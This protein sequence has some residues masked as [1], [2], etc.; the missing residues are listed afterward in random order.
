MDNFRQAGSSLPQNRSM[1]APRSPSPNA[2][3]ND[4]LIAERVTTLLNHY[5]TAADDPAV[6]KLQIHD[7]L[8]DLS[9]FPAAW[10]A[11]ACQE[12]RRSQSRRPL[13]SNIRELCILHREDERRRALPPQQRDFEREAEVSTALAQ[14]AD[15]AARWRK[16]CAQEAGLPT[17][18][19]VMD[20]G[21][22]VAGRAW[23]F[24]NWDGKL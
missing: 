18:R 3:L 8:D 17:F 4:G 11:E 23:P 14:R 9:E 6:R 5:W 15:Y 16:R 20:A 10:V 22:V 12:W 7:W 24:P 1:P 19:D 13:I 2:K 21:L